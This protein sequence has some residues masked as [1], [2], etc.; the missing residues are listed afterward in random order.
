MTETSV[1]AE[2]RNADAGMQ[3]SAAARVADGLAA[4][5]WKP[6]DHQRLA[7]VRWGFS[8]R[9]VQMPEHAI[10]VRQAAR[11]CPGDLVLASVKSIGQHSRLELATGRRSQLYAGDRIVVAY[12]NRYA[13]DQFEAEVPADLGECHLVAAGGIASRMISRNARVKNPTKIEPL[14]LLAHADGTP[15]NLRAWR[16]DS[17][18][19]PKSLPPVIVVAGTAM[20]SGKTT[21]AAS[22]IKGLQR[23]GWRVG[24]AKVTGTGAGGDFWHMKDAGA[25][26][27][28]DFTDA[29]YASTYMLAPQEVEK[30]FL[31]LLSHLGLLRLDAIVVEVA[32]G[33]LQMESAGLLASP[34]FSYYCDGLLFAASDSMGAVAGVQ[35]LQMK[36]LSVA[37]VTGSLTTSPLAIREAT[38]ALGLPVLR[39]RDLSDAATAS[40]LLGTM[41]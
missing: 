24:A 32:D 7:D 13:P 21:A 15:L 18:S 19:I 34:G 1:D 37:A 28:V 40:H 29:G 33:I 2:P 16:L 6:A 23:A 4:E 35:W 9:R 26:C 30:V 31:R 20:N 12:G 22:L 39:K 10:R 17:R 27:V 5:T 8:T 36:G 25:V 3:G 41:R 38:S 14:G 11:P